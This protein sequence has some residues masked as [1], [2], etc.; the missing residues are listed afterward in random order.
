MLAWAAEL[1]SK[2][3]PHVSEATAER[4]VASALGIGIQ[5][6]DRGM[7]VL[8]NE[9]SYGFLGEALLQLNSEKP[10]RPGASL[11]VCETEWRLWGLV[12]LQH[13][14][15]HDDKP[16]FKVSLPRVQCADDLLRPKFSIAYPVD[17]AAVRLCLSRTARTLVIGRWPEYDPGDVIGS[18]EQE[19]TIMRAMALWHTLRITVLSN[20]PGLPSGPPP[21]AITRSWHEFVIKA[22]RLAATAPG[23]HPRWR[24]EVLRGEFA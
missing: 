12:I 21:R 4:F 16:L 8:G 23:R 6:L 17:A 18:L 24:E 15:L 9:R 22:T 7:G 13:I 10:A 11:V 2:V 14:R 19:E 3:P 5:L 20:G 1:S